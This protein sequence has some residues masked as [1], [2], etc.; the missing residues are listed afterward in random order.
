MGK[1]FFFRGKFKFLVVGFFL[2]LSFNSYADDVKKSDKGAEKLETITV[3][4]QKRKENIQDVPVSITALSDIQVED[5]GIN[6]MK[7]LSFYTPNLFIVKSGNHAEQ[8]PIIRGMFNRMNPNPTVG[9][10]VDGVSYSRHL[11]YDPDFFDIERIEV[12]KGPQGTLFGRNTEAGAINIITKKPGNESSAK[13]SADFGSYNSQ[14]YYASLS[15]PVIK[16]RLFAGFS[17]KRY[18]SD[19]YM[20]ND[21]TGNKKVEYRDDLNGRARLRWTPTDM[22]DITI[23]AEASEYD[24]GFGCFSDFDNLSSHVNYDYEG[25]VENSQNGQS[26]NIEYSGDDFILTSI[27]GLRSADYNLKYD[28]DLTAYDLIRNYYTQEH[29]QMTQEIRI[30]STEKAEGLQ[31]LIGAFYLGEDFDL[32][33]SYDYPIGFPQYNMPAHKQKLVSKL[34]TMNYAVFGQA[35]LRVFEKLGVTAGLRY[36]Y[37]KKD[38]KGTRYMKPDLYGQGMVDV[39]DEKSNSVWLPKFALD[40]KFTSDIMGYTSVSRGYTA[41]AFNDLDSTPEVHGVPY[42]AEYSWN[43]ECGIKTAWFSNRLIFNS[44]LFYVDWKDKQVFLHSG[45]VGNIFKNAAEATSKGFEMDVLLR[46]FTG[47]EIVGGLGYLKAD[48]DEFKTPVYNLFGE[49]IAEK[50]YEDNRLEMAPELSYNLAVQYR[51]PI[52][53]SSVLFSRVEIQGVGDFYY[54]LENEQE[55]KSY[56]LVNAKIGYEGSLMGNDFSVYL[57]AKN[58]FDEEYCASAW[59]SQTRG[60]HGRLGDPRMVGIN[61]NLKF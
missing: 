16:D 29:N 12:L 31:W 5:A 60:Y 39:G 43:Y 30:A 52:F 58:I 55:Q 34:N 7:D 45:A 56:E 48:Y 50:D 59:G 20:E 23:N 49:K 8:A 44:S 21:F 51:Y 57:W 4:A 11:S 33:C 24:D 28:M 26:L 18:L 22:L 19:G 6:D 53:S 1:M 14:G 25:K 35:E 9:M 10:F 40:Y 36:D 27:T 54:D 61:L 46:P 17:G 2:V 13:I 3:T 15:G 32:K 37:D 41:G 47:L 42:D 38:F